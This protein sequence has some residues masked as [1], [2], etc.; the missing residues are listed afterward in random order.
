M[1]IAAF[2]HGLPHGLFAALGLRAED[3]TLAPA[4][5]DPKIAPFLEPFMD[6]FAA[7]LLHRL[8]GGALD[9]CDALIFL[10][11][12]PG[13]L[14]AFHYACEFERRGL[15]PPQAP[16]L[17]LLNLIPAATPAAEAY[18]RTELDR[19]RATLGPFGPPLPPPSPPAAPAPGPGPRHALLGAPL[20]NGR[21]HRLIA[22]AGPLVFDQ[23]AEDAARAAAGTTLSEAL[24]AQAANPF[25]ARQ[26]ADAYSPAIAR[27]IASRRIARVVWQVDPHDD[28]WGWLAPD[29]RRI[30]AAAGADVLDLGTLP[31]WPSD[32]DLAA[33]AAL[34]PEAPR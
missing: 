15:L 6:P 33:V 3:V 12:S 8:A 4:P 23:Q 16:R 18:N 20:G 19:L 11:E 9:G 32:A 34:F 21:L 10:R 5:A 1:R 7:S 14:P 30:A 26:P 29:I 24:A 2:G 27:E 25:A 17:H 28:L 22:R 13:A 31:R